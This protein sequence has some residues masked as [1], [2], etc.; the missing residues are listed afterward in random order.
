MT[1]RVLI[2]ERDRAFRN[3]IREMMGQEADFDVVGLARDSQ[4]AIQLAMQLS[5]DVALIAYDLQGLTGPQTCEILSSLSPGIMIALITDAKTPERLD[6]ALDCGARAVIA[7][8]LTAEQVCSQ[9]SDLAELKRRQESPETMQWADPAR[10]PKIITVTG[11]KGGV[12]KSTI[13]ANLST[14]MA[15]QEPDAVIL[16]DFYTQ[17]GDIP[18]MFNFTPK[19]TIADIMP[20]CADLD[21]DLV[22][23]YV[24]RHS[25]G[26]HLLVMSVE[27]LPPEVVD[28]ECLDSLFYVLKGQYRYIIV[29]MPPVLYTTTLHVLTHSNMILLIANLLD[30]TTLTD[31]RKFYDTLQSERISDDSIGIVLNR[32]SR[33][34]RLQFQDVQQM[35]AC[36]IVAQIPD[37]D[38]VITAINEGRPAVLMDRGSAFTRGIEQIASVL[39]SPPTAAKATSDAVM[40]GKT[41]AAI[42]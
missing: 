25:S 1:T 6:K 5:P 36:Q 29:D 37:Y 28:L 13:A 9:V 27:P 2:A 10:Y 41:L 8:P 31:T 15:W 16:V 42:R 34:N 20:V 4:E 17:F 18:T 33:T 38:K 23:S 32:I 3:S 35:F 12:G 40:Y 14:V 21:I 26:V 7:K 30:L 19:G 39:S 22:N 24:T 11:A